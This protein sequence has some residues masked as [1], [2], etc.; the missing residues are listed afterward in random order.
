MHTSATV[1][2]N[3]ITEKEIDK[4]L[5]NFGGEVLAEDEE[6]I[7]ALWLLANFVYYNKDEVLHLCKILMREFIHKMLLRAK[8]T[9]NEI[10]NDIAEI[11]VRTRF[12]PLG[13][14]SESGGYILYHFRQINALHI[15]YFIFPETGEPDSI[16]NLVYVD[17]VTLT[18]GDNGFAF[19]TLKETKLKYQ[20][21]RVILL[22][23]IAS[24][25]AI[26]ELKKIGV[27]VITTITLD[28]RN[29][30]FCDKSDLFHTFPEY[31][32]ICKNFARH[33]GK[34]LDEK[35]PMGYMGG[36]YAFGFFYNTPNNTL[37]I[38]WGSNNNWYPIFKRFDKPSKRNKMVIDERFI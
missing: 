28:E 32:E 1:W 15:S 23:L 6:T 36:E 16:E 18:A 35:D 20:N 13:E 27:E 38:F 26:D 30:C 7:L 3:E 19:R 9:K 17:D 4:W 21:K 11:I 14:A 12:L 29:K 25:N 24:E 37:P 34:K 22:T 31:I 33:Y 10:D 8:S 5:K 2:K